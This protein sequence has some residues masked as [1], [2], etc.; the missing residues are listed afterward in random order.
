MTP[1]DLY[2]RLQQDAKD[3]GHAY[4]Q[5]WHEADIDGHHLYMADTSFGDGPIFRYDL[6]TWETDQQDGWVPVTRGTD[7]HDLET[8]L[9]FAAKAAWTYRLATLVAKILPEPGDTRTIDQV[10]CARCDGEGHK[11]ITFT[12]FTRPVEAGPYVF[13]YW[14]TCP[15]TGEPIL[16]QVTES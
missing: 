8:A 10:G 3:R 6:H 4:G 1:D 7:H 15:T 9:G 12:K 5:V 2:A 13:S 11:Q 16:M 14:A